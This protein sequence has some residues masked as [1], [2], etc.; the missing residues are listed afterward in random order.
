MKQILAAATH[1]LRREE[2]EALEVSYRG[3]DYVIQANRLQ[4]LNFFL[5]TYETQFR[6]SREVA[7]TRDEL[8]LISENLEQVVEERTART[9]R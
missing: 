8:A 4:M 9:Q 6:H 3:K 5:T 2:A 1:R 7:S